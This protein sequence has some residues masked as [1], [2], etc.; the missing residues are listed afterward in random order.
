MALNIIQITDTHLS[1][2]SPARTEDLQRCLVAIKNEPKIPD[3][4]LHTGDI[5]HNGLMSEY[6]TAMHAIENLGLPC[7]VLPGNRD[8]RQTMLDYFSNSEYLPAESEFFQ[9]T[10]EDYNTRFV[11]LDTHSEKSNKGELCDHRF[12]LF[13]KMLAADTSRPIVIVMHHTPFEVSE[14]PDPF[15]FDNWQQVEKFQQ[16]VNE[17]PA[18]QEIIC[19][20]VHR[21]IEAVVANRPAKALTCLAGDLRKGDVLEAERALP[22]FRWHRFE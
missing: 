1:E 18:V 11:V 2:E 8:N 10:I 15:Q 21:N 4:L 16:I 6:N 3:F 20:H 7:F 14:I 19:G 17:H 5:T 9:Y 22:V 12:R 13:E